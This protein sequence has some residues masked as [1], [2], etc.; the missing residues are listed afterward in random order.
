MSG[1][2]SKQPSLNVGPGS[3]Q[4]G[5]ATRRGDGN[6]DAF[7]LSLPYFQRCGHGNSSGLGPEM[8]AGSVAGSFAKSG[9]SLRQ[10]SLQ[11][12][13]AMNE[14]CTSLSSCKT[15]SASAFNI[16]GEEDAQCRCH[17][18]CMSGRIINAE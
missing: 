11:P 6:A 15:M 7:M 1:E 9:S 5:N 18:W 14:E 4:A 10:I 3:M 12:L 16:S 2:L 17:G 13:A 8:I